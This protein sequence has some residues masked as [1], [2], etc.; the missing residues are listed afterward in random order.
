MA[1]LNPQTNS[2]MKNKC[3][4]VLTGPTAVGK[5]DLSIELARTFNA[6]ILS[7]D[8]RQFYRELQIGTAAPSQQTLE[9]VKHHFVGHLSVRDYYNVAMFEKQAL[10]LLRKLFQSSDYAMVVGGSGL[11][12]DTL[13]FGIDELPDPDPA[14]RLEVHHLYAKEG[15]PGLRKR[16]RQVD[17]DYHARVDPANHKRIMRALEVCLATGKTFTELRTNNQKQ[18]PFSIK[19]VVLHRSRQELF[20]RINKRVDEMITDGLI[21]ETISLYDKRHLNALNTVGYKELFD[22]LSNK[23]SLHTAI[24]KI[25]TNTRRYAKRQQTWFR[26]YDDAAVF[27]PSE[28]EKILDYVKKI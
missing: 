24:E 22:W 13:C 15:L 26:R 2:W 28:K 3:L 4:L 18:R 16:L 17:P 19:K 1:M 25:M 9:A 21:E 5:T 20:S 11:Y 8:A 6:E 10:E 23:W 7:A 12:I 14:I 27:H